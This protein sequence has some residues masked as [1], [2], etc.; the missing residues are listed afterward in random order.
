MSNDELENIAEGAVSIYAAA[1]NL[2]VGAIDLSNL[3]NV[4]QREA[5]MMLWAIDKYVDLH[6]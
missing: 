6:T 5:E 2:R 4:S 3:H 1:S